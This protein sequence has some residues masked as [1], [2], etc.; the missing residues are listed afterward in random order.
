MNV[1]MAIVGKVHDTLVTNCNKR[2][3]IIVG[4]R[5]K[6]ASWSIARILLLEGMREPLFIVC[7]REVQKTIAHSVKKLLEET[8]ASFQF[9]F[10][11]KVFGNEIRGM[12]GTKFIF[13]GLH[14]YNAD[15]IKSL[16]GADRCWVAEAQTISRRS[17][18]IL[19]PTIRKQGSTVWWDFNPRYD[20]DPIWIDYIL[21]TD[22]NA[23]VLWISWR[24][25]P[26][27]TDALVMEKES[28]YRRNEVEARHIWEGELRNAGDMFVCPS[29]LVDVAIHKDVAISGSDIVVGADIAHQGGDEIVF[30]KRHGVKTID[31]YFSHHQDTLKT[32]NDLMAFCGDQSI[33]VNIDN[34]DIGKAVADI[35]ASKKYIVHR[36]N[37]GGTASDPEHY[38]DCA[39][40]MY[41]NLGKQLDK[42]DIP[43][44]EEL[45][46]Q[47]IQRKYHY[48]TGKRG[49]EVMKIESK[50]DFTEHSMAINKSPDRADALVLCFYKPGR[51]GNAATV[52]YN[53]Y[54]GN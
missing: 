8:I 23:E 26:W 48:I 35:L 37:F 28:D 1:D 3:R 45:R 27:F 53:M 4:G 12:N 15:N 25:N 39:T 14:D 36:I 43:N 5:G 40:E 9:D 22:P 50:D 29:A 52:N 11:Y 44:D 51:S 34:G 7:V 18:N 31:K 24:D 33:P 46:N 6:G 38:E 54:G 17:I 16:E 10:F 19:R 32:A 21:N 2:H 30:Y 41:F 13:H 42:I 20:T 49:Y 47:L